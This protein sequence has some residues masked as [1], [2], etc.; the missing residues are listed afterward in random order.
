MG[1]WRFGR[2]AQSVGPT[3]GTFWKEAKRRKKG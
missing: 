2:L 1:R 3:V